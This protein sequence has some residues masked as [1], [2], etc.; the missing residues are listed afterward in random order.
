[1][2]LEKENFKCIKED[3]SEEDNDKQWENSK[4]V[5]DE[6]IKYLRNKDY[7][8]NLIERQV[9]F[10]SYF[11]MNYFFVYA[12]ELSILETD[13]TIIRRF[14]ENWYIRKNQSPKFKEMK[15]ILSALFDFFEFIHKMEFITIEL[16]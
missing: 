15:E 13:D 4:I 14:L 7:K 3:N 6:F 16:F 5:F 11:V 2:K 9:V 1:M 10:S 12:D 8:D